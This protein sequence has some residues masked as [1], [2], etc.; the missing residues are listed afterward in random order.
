MYDVC[1]GHVDADLFAFLVV[2]R[3]AERNVEDPQNV[4]R[5]HAGGWN[6]PTRRI[7]PL[8]DGEELIVSDHRAEELQAALED[9]LHERLRLSI[10]RVVDER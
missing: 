10:Y 5:D 3:L 7:R 1:P 9:P 4:G 8:L 2:G 6:A